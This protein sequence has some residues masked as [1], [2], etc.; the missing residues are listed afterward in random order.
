MTNKEQLVHLSSRD[1]Y[2]R[3]DWLYHDYAKNYTD[4]RAA[5]INLINEEYKPVEP[6]RIAELKVCPICLQSIIAKSD[7]CMKCK[8]EW[9]KDD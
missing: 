9:Q 7:R 4:S 2:A 8:T 3:I 5:I 6:L 1:W